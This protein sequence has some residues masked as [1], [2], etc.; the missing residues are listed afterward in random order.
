MLIG[1]SR[2]FAVN[3]DGSGMKQLGQRDSWLDE[4]LRQTDGFIVDWL[5]GADGSVLMAREYIPEAARVESR[6]RRSTDG[7]GVDRVNTLTLQATP[8]EKARSDA[9]SYMSDGRGNVR[10][11]AIDEYDGSGHLTGRSKIQYRTAKSRDWRT[12]SD[13]ED[14]EITPLAVDADADALYALKQLNGRDALY[15]IR[16]SETPQTELVASHPRVDI[17]TV[18]RSANGQKV[19]GYEFVEDKREAVYFDAEYKA[20]ASSLGKALPHLPLIRFMGT[21]QDGNRTLV[22]AASDKEPGRYYFFDRKAKQLGELFLARPELERRQLAE[23]KP[24]TVKAADGTSI[25]AYLTLPAGREARGLPAVVLP[26]GGPSSRDEWGFDWLA[27][28]LAARGYAVIQPNYRGSAGFGDEWLMENGFK[29]WR[30]SIGDITSSIRWLTD[31]GIAHPDKLAIVGWSY[32]GYAALQAAATEPDLFKAVA[33]I[34]PVTDLALLKTDSEGFTNRRLVREFVG[35]G[36]H[37]EQG[38]PLRQAASIKVP[39]LLAHGDK[40]S[41]VNVEHSRRMEGALRSAGTQ[42]EFLRFST[43]DHQLD[44]GEARRRTLTKIGELLDRTIGK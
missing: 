6:L 22:Y 3:S 1:F 24:V 9:A 7:L 10:L 40:D 31:Q 20:L 29:S 35:S 19:I 42:V 14:E 12:L 27:Q 43:L 37:I 16:L 5:P 4:R 38:S 33:A 39:V 28:F 26:H 44:D 25:P 2:L 21:S 18:I 17:D 23:V 41:N 15:R 13:Y 30:T 36:P 8:V 11:L 34:A 32:G